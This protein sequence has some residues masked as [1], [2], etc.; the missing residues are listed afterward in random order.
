[1]YVSYLV[2]YFVIRYVLL[3]VLVT[4]IFGKLIAASFLNALMDN[5][6]L[7]SLSVADSD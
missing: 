5:S 1:M 4:L 6:L 2:I 3:D 7:N